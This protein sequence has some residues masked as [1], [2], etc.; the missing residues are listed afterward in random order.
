MR[1]SRSGNR[2]AEPLPVGLNGEE[3]DDVLA[4]VAGRLAHLVGEAGLLRLPGL[5]VGA[6]PFNDAFGSHGVR[7]PWLPEQI[8]GE[9]LIPVTGNTPKD[10]LERQKRRVDSLVQARF[11]SEKPS[12]SDIAF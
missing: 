2:R 12:K 3:R 7:Q 6:A 8:R 11:S 4:R 5:A 10:V 9:Q 1:R